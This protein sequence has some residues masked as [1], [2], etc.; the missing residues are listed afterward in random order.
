MGWYSL[1]LLKYLRKKDLGISQ[2]CYAEF[3][4]VSRRTLS[5]IE[6][7]KGSQAQG[8]IDKTFKPFGIKSSL[9]PI[10]PHIACYLLVGKKY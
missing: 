4:R 7:N 1:R 6:Q 5:D 8:I 3:I 2:T 10:Q 9:T